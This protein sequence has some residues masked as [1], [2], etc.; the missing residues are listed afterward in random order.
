[1]Y[2]NY[3]HFMKFPTG[4][5][6]ES[7]AGAA[8]GS[9]VGGGG[10]VWRGRRGAA[11]CGHAAASELGGGQGCSSALVVCFR[12]VGLCVQGR[13]GE[14]GW[15]EARIRAQPQERADERACRR[16]AER[17]SHLPGNG[18]ETRRSASV[19]RTQCVCAGG[20]CGRVRGYPWDVT[21]YPT[22][23]EKNVMKKAFCLSTKSP[24]HTWSQGH[25]C[26]IETQISLQ[27]DF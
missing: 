20:R 5:G 22:C 1:M 13:G 8:P 27:S 23:K 15:S 21:Y 17:P 7:G 18:S 12:G 25:A 2:G 3:S 10:P 16:P 24:C 6:G 4:F 26:F 9:G 11:T 19:V 14:R